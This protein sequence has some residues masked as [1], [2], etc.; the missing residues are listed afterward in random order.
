M[1]YVTKYVVKDKCWL[2]SRRPGIGAGMLES[3]NSMIDGLTV[4]ERK[5]LSDKSDRDIFIR[6]HFNAYARRG[7]TIPVLQMGKY[8]YPIHRYFKERLRDLRPN[9]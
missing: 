6:R 2:M 8:F 7:R 4:F 5:K 1:M 3:L 9:L